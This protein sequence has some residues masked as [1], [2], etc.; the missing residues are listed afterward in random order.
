MAVQTFDNQKTDQALQ[1]HAAE[2]SSMADIGM[3]A[4]LELMTARGRT[5]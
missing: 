3:Q 2:V 5:H 1:T 4:L